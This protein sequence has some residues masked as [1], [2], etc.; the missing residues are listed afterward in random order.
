M[1]FQNILLPGVVIPV[2]FAAGAFLLT[3]WLGKHLSDRE[4]GSS[5]TLAAAFLSASVAMTGWPRWPP[6][7]SSQ[8]LFYLVAL[9]AALSLLVSWLRQ[10]WVA[11][12]VRGAFTALLLYLL[13]STPLENTWTRGQAALWLA[14]LLLAGVAFAWAWSVHLG[15]AARDGNLLSAAVRLAILGGSALVLGL[16]ESARLAQLAGAVACGVVVI[17]IL[18][19]LLRRRP[20]QPQDSLVLSAALFGLLLIGYFYAALQP[21]PALLLIAA[22]LLLALPARSVWF[23]LVPLVPLAVALGLVIAAAASK[24]ED[25]YDYYSDLSGPAAAP[26]LPFD[27]DP[28]LPRRGYIP[29]LRASAAPPW[30]KAQSLRPP[31]R[32]ARNRK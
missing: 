17:E 20:W 25:P 2:A 4:P 31:R 28:L 22:V 23:R 18:G 16:S 5:W 9:A 27:R 21:V 10:S 15:A 19:R 11:W 14:G 30:V 32:P 29:K 8:K 6:V 12:V 1:L 26:E 24:P 3:I 13:L 7:G